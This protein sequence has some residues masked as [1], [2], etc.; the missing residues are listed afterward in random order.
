[1]NDEPDISKQEDEYENSSPE[2]DREKEGRE[3][4]IDGGIT[5]EAEKAEV[6]Q[7]FIQNDVPEK[8]LDGRSP[9]CELQYAQ[10]PKGVGCI[11]DHSY[12]FR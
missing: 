2:I 7:R 9:E 12:E 5:N 3:P 11:D 4:L 1:M 8:M 6:P 10:T